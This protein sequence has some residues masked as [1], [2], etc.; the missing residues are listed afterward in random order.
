MSKYWMITNRNVLSDG[1]GQRLDGLTYWTADSDDVA[2]FSNWTK[3]RAEAFQKQLVAAADGFPLIA[4]PTKF[5]DQQHV[6]LFDHGY[7]NGWQAAA[8]R[9]QSICRQLF[10]DKES[11]GLCVL[12][13][14]PSAGSPAEYLPDR[15]EARAAAQDLA[16]VLS[17]LYDWLLK[18]QTDGIRCQ[19]DSLSGCGSVKGLKLNLSFTRGYSCPLLLIL[20][21]ANRSGGR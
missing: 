6:T 19:N 17:A 21:S 15:A 13:S 14:W 16:D 18:K 9:Y 8:Q 12:F 4:D 7:N 5:E 3:T 1:L 10:D 2:T 20:R 11:L